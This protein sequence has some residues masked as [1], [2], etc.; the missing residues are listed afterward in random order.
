[1][2]SWPRGHILGLEGQVLGFG[3]EASR[4][5]KLPCPRLE[6]STFFLKFC[7]KPPETSQKICEY[8]FCFPLL[9]HRR[10]QE[11]GEGQGASPPIEISPMTIM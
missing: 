10:S 4:P 5:R 2:T 11:G 6:D 8:L 7:W 9:Q 1:M 3:F